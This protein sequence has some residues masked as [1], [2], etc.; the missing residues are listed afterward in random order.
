MHGLGG[1]LEDEGRFPLAEATFRRA[2]EIDEKATAGRGFAISM[3][4]N[5]L[6][7]LLAREGR[8]AEAEPLYRR[9]LAISEK[10]QGPIIRTWPRS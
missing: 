10:V 6:A 4:L 3:D 5:S 1:L 9:S 2:L 7:A 8:Y